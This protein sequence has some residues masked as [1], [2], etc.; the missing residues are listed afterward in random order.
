MSTS[1]SVP[2][3][4]DLLARVL[5]P[6]KPGCRYLSGAVAEFPDA[7][8]GGPVARCE[9]TFRIPE[10][11]YIDDTGHF[12]AVELNISYNQLVYTL[13]AQCVASD[14]SEPFAAMTMEEYLRRQLPDVLIH[15]FASKFSRPMDA[16][17]YRGEVIIDEVRDRRR[18]LFVKTRMR[19]W[20]AGGGEA[21]GAVTLAI[22]NGTA[23]ASQDSPPGS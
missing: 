15:D 22:V 17:E 4:D 18:F 12:N 7:G 21:S 1:T 9:G 23:P 14:V 5:F 20:D 16:R 8:A 19:F 3:A 6:Y 2:V 10:S 13:M 11:C